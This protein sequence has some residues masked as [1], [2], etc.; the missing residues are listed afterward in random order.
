M[1]EQ[2][3]QIIEISNTKSIH[4]SI[5]SERITCSKYD[6][7][8][9]GNN[10]SALTVFLRNHAMTPEQ[11][12][13]RTVREYIRIRW[14]ESENLNRWVGSRIGRNTFVFTMSNAR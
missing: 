8:K 14:P 4:V 2:T 6:G 7:T 3:K 13:I 12:V 10:L 11:E 5:S 1:K 9:E